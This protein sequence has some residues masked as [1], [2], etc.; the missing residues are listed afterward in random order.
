MFESA[1]VAGMLRPTEWCG[2]SVSLAWFMVYVI[3]MEPR[4]QTLAIL[5]DQTHVNLISTPQ[6]KAPQPRVVEKALAMSSEEV[7]FIKLRRPHLN[8][9]F[10]GKASW[11]VGSLQSS[12]GPRRSLSQE[13]MP[14]YSQSG[15]YF[16]YVGA[17]NTRSLFLVESCS[18]R[19]EG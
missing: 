17:G 1:A 9:L 2:Y 13:D 3:G 16:I 14:K 6:R 7:F 4:T 5:V 15:V 12:D 8:F 19:E 10:E 18:Q 11:A